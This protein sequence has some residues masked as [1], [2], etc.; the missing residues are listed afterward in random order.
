MTMVASRPRVTP[1]DLLDLEDSER[2]ELVDGELVEKAMGAESNSIATQIV[3]VLGSFVRQHRLGWVLDQASYQCFGWIPDRVRRPD[4]SFIRKQ[5]FSG[6][7]LPRHGH[8]KV[9]P[10]LAVEV[11][12][13]NDN[14]NLTDTKIDEY[15]RAEVSL[16]WIVYPE[17]RSVLVV[18]PGGTAGRLTEGHVLS[19]E[20]VIPG[21]ECMVSDIFAITLAD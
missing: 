20:D 6:G 18:R 2:F 12:S 16:V 1:E 11:L 3:I 5:K 21:F 17:T 13:P 9:A 10:D 19:G 7:V 8:I 14:G 4:V 15:L